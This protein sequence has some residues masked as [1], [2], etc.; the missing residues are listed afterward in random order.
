MTYLQRLLVIEPDASVASDLRFAL[1][2]ASAEVVVVADGTHAIRWVDD[3]GTPDAAVIDVALPDLDAA[4]IIALLR[5]RSTDML[6]RFFG[7]AMRG[8]DRGLTTHQY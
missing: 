1:A 2:P 5:R 8:W 4:T 6:P 7:V 3:H